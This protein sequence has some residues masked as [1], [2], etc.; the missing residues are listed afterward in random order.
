[1]EVDPEQPA[2]STPAADPGVGPPGGKSEKRERLETEPQEPSARRARTEPRRGYKR[3]AESEAYR[4]ERYEPM[5]LGRPTGHLEDLVGA[6]GAA[7]AEAAATAAAAATTATATTA[8]AA[9]ADDPMRGVSP[10]DSGGAS[11]S[12]E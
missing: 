8:A 3:A 4:A 6:A 7:G 5:E 9:A 1:M 10:P 2:V 11:S 12:G